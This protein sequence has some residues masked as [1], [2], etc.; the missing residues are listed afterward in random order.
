V[1]ELEAKVDSGASLSILNEQPGETAIADSPVIRLGEK[2]Q[3]GNRVRQGETKDQT[4]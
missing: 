1:E 2:S 3:M 4:G